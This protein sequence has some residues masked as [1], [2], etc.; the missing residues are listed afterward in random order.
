MRIVLL[1]SE[2]N[3]LKTMVGDVGNTYLTVM[4]GELVYIVVGPEFGFKEGNT[5]VIRK[6]LYGLRTSGARFHEKLADTFQAFDFKPSYADL[7]VWSKDC[8]TYY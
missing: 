4:T 5:L 7:D 2:L 1:V 3:E 8:G 6:A